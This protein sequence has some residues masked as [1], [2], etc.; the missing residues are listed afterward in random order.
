MPFLPECRHLPDALRSWPDLGRGC[1]AKD[2]CGQGRGKSISDDLLE[3]V[4]GFPFVQDVQRQENR[5]AV[6]LSDPDRDRPELVQHLVESG[7]RILEISEEK[8]SL[9]EVYLSLVQE[10]SS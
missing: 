4:R 10:E 3:A 6:A 8:R 9:E 2:D 5:L 7:A 1:G